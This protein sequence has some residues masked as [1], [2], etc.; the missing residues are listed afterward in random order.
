MRCCHHLQV[1]VSVR[2]EET[3]VRALWQCGSHNNVARVGGAGRR[4]E[5]SEEVS[6]GQDFCGQGMHLGAHCPAGSGYPWELM[7]AY[8]QCVHEWGQGRLA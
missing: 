6:S 4:K 8:Q 7:K 3:H 1:L 5:G 2:E